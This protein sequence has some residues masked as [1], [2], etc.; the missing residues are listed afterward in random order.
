LFNEIKNKNIMKTFYTLLIGIMLVFTACDE[1]NNI[2]TDP[3]LTDSE[4]IEGLKTALVVGTDSSSTTL[5]ALNGYYGDALV[6]IAL[7]EDAKLV[8]EKINAILSIAPALS[9]Y[10]NLDAQFD[11]VEKSINRAA[12]EA[13][14]EAA[15]IFKTTITD[16]TITQ[17]L[18]ILNGQ[19]PDNTTTKAAGFD[20]TAATKYLMNKTFTPLTALYAP[21][22]D[23]NLNKDLGLGFSANEAWSTLRTSYN[24]AVTSITNNTLANIALQATGYTLEPLQTVTIGE[25]STQKALDGLFYKVGVEE[26]KIRKNP[27]EWAASAVGNIL[28][29]VFGSGQ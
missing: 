12:E 23:N 13:A 24:N 17:G 28:K 4:I 19:V 14:K 10:L 25:Y 22:I 8:Q 7:P 27:L 1:I 11:A 2:I 3:A 6:R 21:K 15:P 9:S 26:K 16:L 18:N 29:R 20:S 5:S